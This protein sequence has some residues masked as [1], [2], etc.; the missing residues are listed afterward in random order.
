MAMSGAFWNDFHDGAYRPKVEWSA[1]HNVSANTSTITATLK[2]SSN[3]SERD[4]ICV[5]PK[6]NTSITIDGTE[7]KIYLCAG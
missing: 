6:A 2:V 3:Y 1:V 7:K 4:A 5:S